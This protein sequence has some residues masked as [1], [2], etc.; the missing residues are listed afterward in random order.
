[1]SKQDEKK[2]YQQQEERLRSQSEAVMEL[3]TK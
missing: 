3:L 1:M 2:L